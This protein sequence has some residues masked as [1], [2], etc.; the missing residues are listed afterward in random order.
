MKKR[1]KEVRKR[2]GEREKRGKKRRREKG[3]RERDKI[4]C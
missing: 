4:I 1:D 3:E 2:E